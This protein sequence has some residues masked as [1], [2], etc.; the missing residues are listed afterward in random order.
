MGDVIQFKKSMTD[1][2][3][4]K[5]YFQNILGKKDDMLFKIIDDCEKEGYTVQETLQLLKEA[6]S[7]TKNSGHI[8]VQFY[9]IK[10]S[11]NVFTLSWK[12]TRR[13]NVSYRHKQIKQN[14]L[15]IQNLVT[16]MSVIRLFFLECKYAITRAENNDITNESV[17]FSFQ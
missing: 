12:S 14:R 7:Y 8:N 2:E 13:I 5:D 15:Y 3:E 16:E 9:H 4:L 11:C 17:D 1:Y 10:G 6:I